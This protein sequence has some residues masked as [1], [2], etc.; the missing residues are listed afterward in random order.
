MIFPSDMIIATNKELP[1]EPSISRLSY[2]EGLI[3][4]S[5]FDHEWQ[6]RK[7][8]EMMSMNETEL[9]ELE[10]LLLPNQLDNIFER[11]NYSV[12]ELKNRLR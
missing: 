7:E 2:I 1:D 11:G 8:R 3:H 12:T 4:S 10:I 5:T 9:T 6:E